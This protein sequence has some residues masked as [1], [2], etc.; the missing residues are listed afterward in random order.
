LFDIL[1]EFDMGLCI[2]QSG[3][4]FEVIDVPSCFPEFNSGVMLYKKSIA[5]KRLIMRW[6]EYYDEMD[7]FDRNQPSLRRALFHSDIRLATL[8]PEW[9]S[10]VRYPGVAIGKVKI[11]HGRLLD[12]DTPGAGQYH[13]V[14]DAAQIINSITEPRVYTQLGGIK[15]HYNKQSRLL[16][17]LRLSVMRYGY[18]H[19]IKY[20]VITFGETGLNKIRNFKKFLAGDRE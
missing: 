13:D 7:R 8:R 19:A 6:R 5:T 12:I 3:T 14:Q 2:S 17:R 18:K 20:S 15:L 16:A 10:L 9:N 4:S 1:D 11:F